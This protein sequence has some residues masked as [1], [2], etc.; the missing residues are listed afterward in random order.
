M[1]M[2]DAGLRVL[3]EAATLTDVVPSARIR[4]RDGERHLCVVSPTAPDRSDG[5]PICV[6]TEAITTLQTVPLFPETT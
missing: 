4:I 3:R 2:T 1:T 6:A 5:V